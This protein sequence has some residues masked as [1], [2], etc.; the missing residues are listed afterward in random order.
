MKNDKR[1]A[2][3]ALPEEMQ[4]DIKTLVA[5]GMTNGAGI[6]FDGVA[7]YKSDEQLPDDLNQWRR[8][9]ATP[10]S[11]EFDYQPPFTGMATRWSANDVEPVN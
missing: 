10:K 1:A 2:W 6:Y 8:Y 5:S 4:N 9:S 7:A 11:T 3:R